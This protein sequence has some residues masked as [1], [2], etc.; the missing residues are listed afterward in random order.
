MF[1]THFDLPLGEDGSGRFVP[2]IV[3][4]MVYLA[5]LSVAAGMAVNRSVDRWDIGLEGTAT[6]EIA[7]S[8]SPGQSA[9]QRLD[10]ALTLL[11]A[12]AGVLGAE[13]LTAEEVAGL[14]E[15]WLGGG[16]APLDL[17]IP[18]LIDVRLEPGTLL[19]LDALGA[20][21]AALVPGA[22]LDNH[23]IWSDRL[24]AFGRSVQFTSAFVVALVALAGAGTVVFAT[25]AGLAIH[26]EV[27]ELMHLVGSRD[28]YIAGQFQA[29]AMSLALRGGVLGLVLGATTLGIFRGI[30]APIQGSLLP[31]MTITAGAWA[32][33]ATLPLIAGLIAIVTARITVVRTLRTM[34]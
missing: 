28:S 33:L 7:P 19:D 31:E 4:V 34:P 20:Q 32:A 2:W 9:G 16:D 11:R 26:R 15:P 25:R 13:P 5:T 24:T 18:Q 30:N 22:R 3:A 27:I 29:H 21:L 6:V 1:R 17:P 12:T 10:E 23:R 14:L 8:V